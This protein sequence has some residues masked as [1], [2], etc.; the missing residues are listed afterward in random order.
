V[1]ET[2]IT[3]GTSSLA[4]SAITVE[5]VPEPSTIFMMLTGLGAMVFA[6]FRFFHPAQ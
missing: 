5:T 1:A 6:G 3:A 4:L 2:A